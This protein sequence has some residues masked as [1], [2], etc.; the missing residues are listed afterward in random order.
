MATNNPGNDN[1]NGNGNGYN[2][3]PP[4]PE[5]TAHDLEVSDKLIQMSMNY[6]RRR[7]RGAIERELQDLWCEVPPS[8]PMPDL[9]DAAELAM[10][11]TNY[12]DCSSDSEILH[13][14][15]DSLQRAYANECRLR[16]AGE[17][18]AAGNQV[19]GLG[20]ALFVIVLLMSAVIALVLVR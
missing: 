10:L 16:R 9:E 5:P 2:P 17:Q 14:T 18:R 3:H 8:T 7:D 1:G 19:L 4:A 6:Q 13:N 12:S 11:V 15:I 20:I